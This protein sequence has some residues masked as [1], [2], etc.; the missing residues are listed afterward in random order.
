MIFEDEADESYPPR[1]RRFGRRNLSTKTTTTTT[2]TMTKTIGSVS[3]VGNESVGAMRRKVGFVGLGNM[4]LPMAVGLARNGMRGQGAYDADLDEGEG[5]AG[6][7]PITLVA[8]DPNPDSVS[9]IVESMKGGDN[10]DADDAG[11]YVDVVVVDSARDVGLAGCDVIFTSLP[12]DEIV[13]SVYDDLLEGATATT[14][15]RASGNTAASTGETVGTVFVDCSTVSPSLSR[16]LHRDVLR[17]GGDGGDGN[18]DDNGFNGNGGF[19]MLD[20]PV[21]GGVVG[22]VSQTLTF[23]IGTSSSR[24]LYIALPYLKIMGKRILSCGGPGSG[25]V[26]KLCNNLAL[27]IQMAGVC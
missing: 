22:A 16:D 19:G 27:G 23:M 13:R 21:S 8:Y 2:T 24:S 11:E 20:A 4:G 3:G 25:S 17:A 14:T 6:G 12:S 5:G 1:R 18:D 7:E 26:T 9:S 10:D 15:T